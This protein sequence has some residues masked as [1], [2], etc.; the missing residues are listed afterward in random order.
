M[1]AL[2]LALMGDAPMAV[3]AT[4]MEPQ[5]RVI[6]QEAAKRG[7]PITCVGHAGEEG[8]IR[9]GV[10]AGTPREAVDG[11]IDT[12]MAVASS[13]GNLGVDATKPTCDQEPPV[14]GDSSNQPVRTLIFTAGDRDARLLTVAHECG[15]AHAYWRATRP[16]DIAR[17][18][19][20]VDAKK[21][22][23]TLDAGENADAR[24]GPVTCFVNLGTR[25]LLKRKR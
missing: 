6:R 24:L 17:F 20:Q 18:N 21:Y 10:P 14:R 1:F 5:L 4:G 16:E 3:A 12:L 19:G 25:P 13:A 15:F 7:W 8:V 2:A 23:V 11:F 9:V 22:P